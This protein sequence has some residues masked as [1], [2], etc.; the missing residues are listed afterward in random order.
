MSS[1]IRTKCRKPC[2]I[3]ISSFEDMA[4][5][6]TGPVTGLFHTFGVLEHV[7]HNRLSSEL[8]N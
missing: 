8:L 5:Y 3:R 4:D 1:T 2:S 7:L 6:V